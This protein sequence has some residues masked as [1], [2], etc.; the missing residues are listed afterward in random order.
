MSSLSIVDI[1]NVDGFL[2]SLDDEVNDLN[3]NRHDGQ[4][5]DDSDGDDSS[6]N[7]DGDPR[8]SQSVDYT[9]LEL[10]Q[11]H[12]RRRPA[13]D[14]PTWPTAAP[15]SRSQTPNSQSQAPLSAPSRPEPIRRGRSLQVPSGGTAGDPAW[16]RGSRGSVGGIPVYTNPAAGGCSVQPVPPPNPEFSDPVQE[17][18]PSV[19]RQGRPPRCLRPKVRK[20]GNWTNEQLK[21]ALHAVDEGQS[22]KKAAEENNIPYTSF[23]DHC[24]GKTR[25]RC[26]GVKGVLTPEEEAEIVDFLVRMCD[27]GF[28]LTPSALKMKVFEITQHRWTPFRDGI[29]GDGWMRWFRRRHPELTLRASQG[30]ESARARALCPENVQSLY[31]NLERLYLLNSYPPD[32]I[33]NCDE[34]G[35][36]AGKSS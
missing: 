3:V 33:W 2:D 26:R 31:D 30:L 5:D 12:R 4:G 15:N 10:A 11:R 35:A 6:S 29:P 19:R 28:G 8:A 36:Q 14:S 25:S 16:R 9:Q 24:L 13:A 20:N 1:A 18:M 7:G 27:L 32:R 23:R 21:R 17:D 34:S 22:M